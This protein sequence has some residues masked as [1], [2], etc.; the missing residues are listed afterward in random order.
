[1]RP[2]IAVVGIILLPTHFDAAARDDEVVLAKCRLLLVGGCWL[3]LLTG[4][5]EVDMATVIAM[6][7]NDLQQQNVC[8]LGFSVAQYGRGWADP[9]TSS[10]RYDFEKALLVTLGTG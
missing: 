4:Y 6:R 7:A 10:W 5:T 3:L 9:I 8:L 2:I 1:M